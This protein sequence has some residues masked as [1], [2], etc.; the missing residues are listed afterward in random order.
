MN[1]YNGASLA[2]AVFFFVSAKGDEP[3][4]FDGE[5]AI[6][7]LVVCARQHPDPSFKAHVESMSLSDYREFSKAWSDKV[8]STQHSCKGE[9]CSWQIVTCDDCLQYHHHFCVNCEVDTTLE[10]PQGS[11]RCT[12][13]DPSGT[14]EYE[15]RH[16]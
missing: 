3:S 14:V 8:D 10:P 1:T 5:D 6:D 2:N 9:I 4:D 13:I 7:W 11:H 16:G 12:C 15:A